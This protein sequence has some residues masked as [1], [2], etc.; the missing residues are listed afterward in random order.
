MQRGGCRRQDSLAERAEMIGS[1]LLT[2]GTHAHWT[3]QERTDGGCTLSQ[4]ETGSAVQEAPGLAMAQCDRHP[5]HDTL[6]GRLDQLDLKCLVQAFHW[7][8]VVH[9]T[10]FRTHSSSS[11]SV[12][13]ALARLMCP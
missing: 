8:D 11:V 9:L 13:C 6:T 10:G 5:H 7:G 1:D 3:V 12:C 4:S 2:E